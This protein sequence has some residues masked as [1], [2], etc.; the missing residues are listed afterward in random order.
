MFP[1][2]NVILLTQIT[3]NSMKL[4]RMRKDRNVYFQ[5]QLSRGK[6]LS[7]IGLSLLL[8]TLMG[9]SLLFLFPKIGQDPQTVGMGTEQ[10][11]NQTENH[12]ENNEHN[13][14]EETAATI[15]H[16]F[17][18]LSAFVLQGGIFSDI[19]NAKLWAENFKQHNL[20]PYIWK[21]DEYYYLFASI[22]KD[23]DSA[24]KIK[25]QVDDE[26]LEIYVKEWEA[27]SATIT[28]SKEEIEWLQAYYDLWV[29]SLTEEFA[30]NA[31]EDLLRKG[32]EIEKLQDF[33]EQI[34]LELDKLDTKINNQK[35]YI[36][37]Y[38]WNQYEIYLQN[39]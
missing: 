28:A 30:V 25:E 5:A 2:K 15:E 36:L 12:D 1:I 31:W 10:E 39:L 7:A 37:L 8:G 13:T 19:E 14:N 34:I 9:M 22:A 27:T 3:G 33:C 4:D 18:R 23:K 21:R 16:T 24:D 26:Q 32:K 11:N 35:N 17:G 38:L 20:Y 29:S 6:I